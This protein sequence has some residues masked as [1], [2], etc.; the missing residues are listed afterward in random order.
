[1]IEQGRM[2]DI[3]STICLDYTLSRSGGGYNEEE[4]LEW[5]KKIYG[6]HN[7]VSVWSPDYWMTRFADFFSL[8]DFED[9]EKIGHRIS[10]VINDYVPV[11]WTTRFIYEGD[12]RSFTRRLI[13][14]SGRNSVPLYYFAVRRYKSF[15]LERVVLYARRSY[16]MTFPIGADLINYYE[17]AV[18][19]KKVYGF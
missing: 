18:N 19:F 1:M 15:H 4:Y 10:S 8:K 5:S 17:M 2:E 12:I 14:K 11:R 6:H 16:L 7:Q 9:L 13:E 3:A